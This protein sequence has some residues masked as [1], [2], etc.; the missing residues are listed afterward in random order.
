MR[1][2]RVYLLTDRLS[3][4]V[5]FDAGPFT[6][7]FGKNNTGK[8]NILEGLYGLFEDSDNRV[9]R[10]RSHLP[11]QPQYVSVDR[12][13]GGDVHAELE[14]GVAFDDAVYAAVSSEATTPPR[15]IAFTRHGLFPGDPWENPDRHGLASRRLIGNLGRVH[16]AGSRKRRRVNRLGPSEL[17]D[18]APPE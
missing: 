10:A 9:V 15:C 11:G 1:L 8:T 2:L 5:E 13:S 18:E 14:Q 7:L 6:V 12:S 3:N 17:P 4:G 16:L